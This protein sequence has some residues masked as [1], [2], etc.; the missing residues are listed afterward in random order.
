MVACILCALQVQAHEDEATRSLT[1]TKVQE[2][3]TPLV[4]RDLQDISVVSPTPAP[5]FSNEYTL[6]FQ[7]IWNFKFSN[8]TTV[9]EPTEEEY[10]GLFGATMDWLLMEVTEEYAKD[11]DFA[12]KEIVFSHY[13]TNFEA[14]EEYF[15]TV[16]LEC[17]CIFEANSE[18]DIP[19][20][21]P[22]LVAFSAHFNR[23]VFI[24]D[25]LATL[26]QPAT[27][28]FRTVEKIRYN[29]LP[30]GSPSLESAQFDI[31][32][33]RLNTEWNMTIGYGFVDQQPTLEEYNGFK[34]AADAWMTGLMLDAYPPT[35]TV[36]FHQLASSLYSTTYKSTNGHTV[37][38]STDFSFRQTST[39]RESVDSVWN[40]L[41]MADLG[42]FRDVY[43]H[44]AGPPLSIFNGV[45][46]VEWAPVE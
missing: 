9:R 25:H 29:I 11:D 30:S 1:L 36:Q 39:T 37:R 8:E 40:L 26:A 10:T 5:A 43:L 46:T 7:V 21:Y 15:S 42:R 2:L 32:T 17:Y 33:V 45:V 20:V 38:L 4:G 16:G 35:T 34:A 28:I 13:G 19:A 22:F 24:N 31:T 12:L 44:S 3:K 41:K 27:N 6:P 18:T 14:E 23:T